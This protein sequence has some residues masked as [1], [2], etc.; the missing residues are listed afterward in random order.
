MI[1]SPPTPAAAQAS[2]TDCTCCLGTTMMARSTGPGT[3]S[4]EACAGME[5]TEVAFGF[6]G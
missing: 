3:A 1:T 2:A 5:W 6:T 4:M